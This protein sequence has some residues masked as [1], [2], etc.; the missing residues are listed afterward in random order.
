MRRRIRS[1]SLSV[2]APALLLAG[3]AALALLGALGAGLAQGERSQ[4][5]DL[6][7]SLDGGIAPL[8]LPRDRP[9]PVSVRLAGGLSS[10]D[11]S[12]L[13]RVTRIELGLPERGVVSTRGLPACPL[14]R[15]RNTKNARALAVC[16]P[17]LVGSGQVEAKVV[18]PEQPPFVVHA[19]LLV[20]NGLV[21][22][23]RALLLHGFAARP[24]VSVVIPFYIRRPGGRFGTVMA[25]RLP[26]ALGPWPR[27]ARFEMTLGRRYF[28]RGRE[29]SFLS[30]SCPIPRRFT[31]GFFSLAQATYTLAGGRQVST[32][33]TRGCRG[34]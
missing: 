12:L 2:A 11:G 4:R 17:A 32:A 16:G 20:F 10:A 18:L 21:G 7:V 34:E 30:A 24:P 1:R 23:R 25:A 33:I 9:R 13:P 19:R 5:G 26:S 6:I 29:R 3:L 28:Y 22:G 27:L 15:L 8:K 31:A 14:R